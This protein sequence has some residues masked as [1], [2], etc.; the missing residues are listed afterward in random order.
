[1]LDLR[2]LRYFVAIDRCGSMVLA[3]RQL[4]IAQPA[5]SRHMR[6][7]EALVGFQLLERL[8]RGVRTT[9]AGQI[10]L[11]H[12]KLIVAQV[13]EA[14]GAIRSFAKA[15]GRMRTVKLSLLPSW[16]TSFT[17]AIF[18]AV[19]AKLPNV[20]LQIVEARHEESIRLI[21]SREVDLAITLSDTSEDTEAV[22]VQETLYIVSR[23]KLPSSC[24]LEHAI[25]G[26]KLILPRIQNPLRACIEKAA[27]TV[28]LKPRVDLEIDGQDTV[29][30]AVIA[31]IGDSI[32]SWN[33]VKVEYESGLLSA[34]P[35]VD[36]EIT[37]TVVL[38]KTPSIDVETFERLRD[39]LREIART[40]DEPKTSCQ[41]PE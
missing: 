7:L 12:A 3:S 40:E 39:I 32:L 18:T 22:I 2:R 21:N 23:Q 8:P 35:I 15:R 34:S 1:M 41:P 31:G 10:L 38:R 29:K 20:L 33:S 26:R 25:T 24:T 11:H 9:D 6:E 5:L 36:P 37:R 16:S 13:D 17:P 14:E 19:A 27:N 4:G 30:R 28:N